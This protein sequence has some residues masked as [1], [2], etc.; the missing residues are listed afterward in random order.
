MGPGTAAKNQGEGCKTTEKGE[1][2]PREGGKTPNKSTEKK[3]EIPQ[4]AGTIKGGPDSKL[5]NQKERRQKKT[6]SRRREGELFLQGEDKRTPP[7]GRF[8]RILDAKKEAQP[9]LGRRKKFVKRKTSSLKK[10]AGRGVTLRQRN[11]RMGN[12]RKMKRKKSF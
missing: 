7:R 8:P 12:E 5:K 6:A 11:A 10:G 3:E 9:F 2:S 1:S 4:H